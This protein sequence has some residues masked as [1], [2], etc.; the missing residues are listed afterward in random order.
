MPGKVKGRVTLKKVVRAFAPKSE[1]ASNKFFCNFSMEEYMGRTAN[2]NIPVKSPIFT[3]QSVYK[4]TMGLS[5]SFKTWTR[6]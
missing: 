5:I 3:S 1:E 4:N 2:G 6:T